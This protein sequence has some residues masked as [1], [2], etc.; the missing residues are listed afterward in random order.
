MTF[1]ACLVNALLCLVTLL[2]ACPTRSFAEPLHSRSVDAHVRPDQLVSFDIPAQPLGAAIET[3]GAATGLQ[4]LYDARLAAGRAST[5]LN[6]V[7]TAEAGLQTLLHGTGLVV[8]YTS[9]EALVIVPVP[10]EQAPAAAIGAVALKGADAVQSRYYGLVQAGI[11]NAFC[12]S[13]AARWG[14]DRVTLSLWI[15]STGSVRRF[16]ILGSGSSASLVQAM[17]EWMRQV[18]IGEPPP[19]GMAQPFTIV[20]LARSSSASIDCR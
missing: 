12:L 5:Q 13:A 19:P 1:L 6:G 2:A 17:S 15:D 18:S 4:V 14:T 16:R 11:T 10:P 8:Q 7:F 3:Y 20:I 9:P